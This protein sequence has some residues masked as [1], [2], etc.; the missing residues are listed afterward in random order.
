MRLKPAARLQNCKRSGRRALK[1]RN[2]RVQRATC[3]KLRVSK[4]AMR[5]FLNASPPNVFVGG[6][7][8]N[9]LH[10]RLKHAGM[11]GFG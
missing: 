5:F 11:K 4:L 10:S 8:R 2:Q 9:R 7:V 3:R 1:V 6:P